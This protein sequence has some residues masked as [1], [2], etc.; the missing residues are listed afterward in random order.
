MY[1]HPFLPTEMR[2]NPLKLA[3]ECALSPRKHFEDTNTKW[4]YALPG[5]YHCLPSA[6][7]SLCA[8]PPLLPTE[9]SSKPPQ[10]SFERDQYEKTL[11]ISRPP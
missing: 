8:A 4:K 5:L 6:V 11:K 10:W 9:I 2:D 1:E 3:F 7:G